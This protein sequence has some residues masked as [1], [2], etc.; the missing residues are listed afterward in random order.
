[1]FSV[2]LACSVRTAKR[3]SPERLLIST[4]STPWCSTRIAFEQAGLAGPEFAQLDG[5]GGVA[6]GSGGRQQEA[7][8]VV[9]AGHHQPVADIRVAGV[10]DDHGAGSR[11]AS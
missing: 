6:I 5:R 10:D 3:S 4:A 9:A 2:V 11:P 8:G 7:V 1:V